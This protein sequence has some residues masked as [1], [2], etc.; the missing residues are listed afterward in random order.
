MKR[1][2][3]RRAAFTL[4][5]VLLVIGILMVLATVSV[6]AYSRIKVGQDRNSAQLLIQET[7]KAVEIYQAVMG[8]LPD[9]ETGLK[10][11][12]AKPDDE[13][14]AAKWTSGGG[15]FLKDAKIPVDPWG[16]ELKY[17]LVGESAASTGGP[18]FHISSPGPDKQDG[19]EDDV[20]N[21]TETTG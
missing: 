15:P 9:T 17:E 11:L 4:I 10:A 20:R 2:G 5:E 14:E 16:N 7:A 8:K 3:A 21:W 12:I 6:V 18:A 19:N 13:K 1:S